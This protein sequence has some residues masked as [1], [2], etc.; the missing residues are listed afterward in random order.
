MLRL[1]TA[2]AFALPGKI[3]GKL[4]CSGDGRSGIELHQLQRLARTVQIHR[5]LYIAV[6][7]TAS[8]AK[9]IVDFNGPLPGLRVSGLLVFCLC[10][11]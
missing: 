11:S 3:Y 1:D 7:T 9:G 8:C 10:H 6:G 2:H 5:L 4:H